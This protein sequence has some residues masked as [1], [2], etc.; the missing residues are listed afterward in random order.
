MVAAQHLLLRE[1]VPDRNYSSSMTV[2]P[3]PKE[4][5]LQPNCLQNLRLCMGRQDFGPA[6]TNHSP[7]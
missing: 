2:I 6:V 3:W 1:Y 7:I 4:A 5:V